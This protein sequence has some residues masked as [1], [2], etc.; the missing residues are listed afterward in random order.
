MTTIPEGSEFLVLEGTTCAGD[1]NWWRVQWT[2][3]DGW[4][5]EGADG[6]YFVAPRGVATDNAAGMIDIFNNP[7]P[8]CDE[9]DGDRAAPP[10]SNSS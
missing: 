2:E 6:E 10:F 9:R 3:A 8:A 1:I 7:L 5:A 4:I